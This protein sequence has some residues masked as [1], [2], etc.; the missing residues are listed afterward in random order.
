MGSYMVRNAAALA[1]RPV[2]AY[3]AELERDWPVGAR[4]RHLNS[5]WAGTVTPDPCRQAPGIAVGSDAAHALLFTPPYCGQDVPGVVC[6]A[7]DRPEAVDVA[8]IRTGHL[9]RL[10]NPAS[11][12]QDR[13]GDHGSGH[14]SG[15]ARRRRSRTRSSGGGR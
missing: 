4:V 9:Q 11:H 1:S 15:G 12:P 8:W 2:G 5:G 13:A 6:V 14:A 3:L 7:W 10:T